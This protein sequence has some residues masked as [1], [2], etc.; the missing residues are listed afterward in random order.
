MSSAD[1]AE[2][3][4]ELCVLTGGLEEVLVEGY[5]DVGSDALAFNQLLVESEGGEHGHVAKDGGLVLHANKSGVVESVH[6]V[7]GKRAETAPG[8]LADDFAVGHCLD[9]E[10]GH[11]GHTDRPAIGEDDD[12]LGDGLVGRAHGEHPALHHRGV[13]VAA[14][15]ALVALVA[16]LQA[17]RRQQG[18]QEVL[19]VI[20][21]AAAIAAHIQDDAA[22][23]AA[24][25]E[26]LD[27]VEPGLPHLA[28]LLDMV[29]GGGVRQIEDLLAGGV[30][31]ID[32]HRKAADVEIG[33]VALEQGEVECDA[34]LEEDGIDVVKAGN[35]EEAVLL[36]QA[37]VNGYGDLYRLA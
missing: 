30:V 7:V 3:T 27:G 1:V 13:V 23:G 14:G 4:V 6:F 20:G 28:H 10:G 16:G 8:A 17:A 26:L 35:L 15:A 2:G 19:E 25:V 11:F 24:L 31:Q 12:G 9:A 5:F 32:A 22:E 34:L 18:T 37:V 33:Y 21:V 29:L 36:A